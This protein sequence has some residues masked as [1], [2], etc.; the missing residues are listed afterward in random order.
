MEMEY[1]I[2]MKILLT[3]DDGI[4]AS[5]LA[6]LEGIAKNLGKNEKNS[7]VVV[8]PLRNQSAKSNAITFNQS[9][10]IQKINEYRYAVDGTPTDCI[11]F[12]MEH[13]MKKEKPDFILSGINRGYN[14]SEDIFY[15]GTVGAA[16]EGS[17]R[18]V[19]SI[20]ISQCYD[21]TSLS[22]NDIFAYAK[23]HFPKIFLQLSSAFK[24]TKEQLGPLFN[25]NFPVDPCKPFPLCI[26][27]VQAGRR[28]HSNFVFNKTEKKIK[29]FMAEI[30]S[31]KNNSSKEYENDYLECLKGFI[32]ISPLFADLNHASYLED[33]KKVL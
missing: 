12:A 13:L 5:G 30:S 11:I 6:A 9:L 8:A 10:Q 4:N 33:L 18:G 16:I 28:T 14:L 24:S 1:C 27:P 17:L 29:G 3:N 26:K 20:A 22:R 2:D 19:F 23:K 25:I 15:S 31:R 32:T 7:V 21:T